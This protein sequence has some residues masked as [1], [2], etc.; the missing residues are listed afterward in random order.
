MP[1]VNRQGQS[2]PY[3]DIVKR[4]SGVVQRD[5]VAAIPIALLNRQL[6]TQGR[7]QL[8]PRRWWKAAKLDRRPVAANGAHPHRLL[9]SK[10]SGKAVEI[11]QPPMVVIGIADTG[12]RLPDLIF[13]KTKRTGAHYI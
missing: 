10:N 9:I 8:V 7:L 11:R 2:P 5:Q 13:L 6:I 1:A 3:P 12:N 4:L